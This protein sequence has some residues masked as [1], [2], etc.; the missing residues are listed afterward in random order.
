MFVS[1]VDDKRVE[2]PHLAPHVEKYEMSE[3]DHINVLIIY[4]S[5]C[6]TCKEE[7][8]PA[9]WNNVVF[10]DHKR[11]RCFDPSRHFFSHNLPELMRN[12]PHS[13]TFVMPSDRNYSCY[14][15]TLPGRF[16]REYTAYFT[17]TK[18][19]GRFDGIRHQF[20]IFVESAYLKQQPT[21]GM[22]TNFKAIISKAREGKTVKYRSP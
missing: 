13:K 10:K 1:N 8:S 5:H 4:S 9:E 20:V 17:V 11:P 12:I 16:G 15:T 2:I 21:L 18:R 6:W 3:N 19:K 14:N 22:K 7:D